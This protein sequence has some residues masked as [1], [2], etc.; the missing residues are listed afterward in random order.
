MGILAEYN[1]EL[2]LRDRSLFE[3]NECREDE[4]V[5]EPLVAGKSYPFRKRGQRLYWLLGEVPLI[6]TDGKTLSLPLAS[7]ILT[8]AEHV[9]VENEV[10]TTGTY[11]VVE[12][13]SDDAPHFNG[14]AKISP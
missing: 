4:C 10:W 3:R 6:K 13:F 2:A 12:V 7:I 8:K 14:F 11:E 1:P 5:P 9:V